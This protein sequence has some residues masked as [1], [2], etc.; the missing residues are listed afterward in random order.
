MDEQDQFSAKMT[1]HRCQY[2]S[3][4]FSPSQRILQK[5]SFLFHASLYRDMFKNLE[6][7]CKK[8]IDS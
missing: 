7:I 2:A 5:I 4:V 6:D 3:P 1:T 8:F